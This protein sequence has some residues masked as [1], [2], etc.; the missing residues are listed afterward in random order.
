[1]TFHVANDVRP[2]QMLHDIWLY[3]THHD[4]RW[5]PDLERF[6]P[7]R[8]SPEHMAALPKCA[9]IPFGAGGRTCLGKRF[10]LMEAQLLL[11]SIAQR[12]RLSLQSDAP[13]KRQMTVTLSPLGGLPMTV[14]R[15]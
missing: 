11:A 8:F 4:T 13:V 15:R 2:S 6:D 12:Y 7:E 9:Y 3:L 10:A 5:F 1:M 14:H